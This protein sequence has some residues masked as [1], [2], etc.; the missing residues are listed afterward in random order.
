[1]TL[2][3]EV[4]ARKRALWQGRAKVQRFAEEIDAAYGPQRLKNAVETDI[5]RRFMC[6]ERLLDVGIG[7]G[8]VSLPLLQEGLRLTGVDTS[9]AMIERCRGNKAEA[10]RVLGLHRREVYR[11][12]QRKLPAK[13]NFAPSP[14][15]IGPSV[16]DCAANA[17]S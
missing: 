8:R 9:A 5:V 16:G 13:E 1:M 4:V 15:A 7:T 12:L 2:D 11:I 3:S 10:A 6:G 14:L 17:Y